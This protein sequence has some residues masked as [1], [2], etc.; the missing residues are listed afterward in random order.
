MIANTR[1]FHSLLFAGKLPTAR[2]IRDYLA[3]TVKVMELAGKYEWVSVLKFDD[4]YR[5]LQ[6]TYSFPWSYDSHHLHEVTLVPMA[7]VNKQVVHLLPHP[8]LRGRQLPPMQG[9]A[10]L[11]AEILILRAATSPLV[12]LRMFATGNSR[13][14]LVGGPTQHL[15]TLPR[16]LPPSDSQWGFLPP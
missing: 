10:G 7:Q 3:Y 6:A 8:L 12:L 2:D 13:A 9:M 5:Q 1:I 11:F 15:S 14:R 16:L 4:E